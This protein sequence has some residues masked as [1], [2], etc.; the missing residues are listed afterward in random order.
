MAVAEYQ[1]ITNASKKLYVSQPYLST[2]IRE[3]EKELGINL[4]ER[5]NR[6]IFLSEAGTI[7]LE[8]VKR[9]DL[10]MSTALTRIEM[11]KNSNKVHEQ[12]VVAASSCGFLQPII[13]QYNRMVSKIAVSH[14]VMSNRM[15][16]EGI[17]E[18]RIEFGLAC[19][20]PTDTTLDFG[21]IF[22]EEIVAIMQEELHPELETECNLDQLRHDAIITSSL[23]LDEE[24]LISICQKAGFTPQIDFTTNEVSPS[25][26]GD[27]PFDHRI[28][29]VPLHL[30]DTMQAPLA[31]NHLK[32]IHIRDY[33]ATLSWGLV[34]RKAAVFTKEK[35]CFFKF[36]DKALI[37]QIN[38]L[39]ATYGQEKNYPL[40]KKDIERAF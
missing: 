3:L 14:L 29:Y 20:A 7:F 40:P 21:P 16:F 22:I 25:H 10:E 33:F 5:R 39:A 27:I 12:L 2:T 26:I 31:E 28:M 15:L 36:L 19:V 13:T 38:Q 17:A 4:F 32:V 8:Y 30:I 1:S 6:G 9:A 37:E 23:F 34:F 11:L 35:E 18:D 24:C